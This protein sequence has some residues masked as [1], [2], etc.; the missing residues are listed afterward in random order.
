MTDPVIQ[1]DRFVEQQDQSNVEADTDFENHPIDMDFVKA[2]GVG[3]PPRG[4]VGF[5]V[6]RI[7]M[8]LINSASIRD[9]FP[10][11]MMKPV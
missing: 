2:I 1:Y 5:G 10:F 6:D 3:I 8:L 9:I 11:L 7:I 4:G